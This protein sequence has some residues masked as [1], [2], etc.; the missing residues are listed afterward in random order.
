MV[1]CKSNDKCNHGHENK[2]GWWGVAKSLQSCKSN[3]KCNHDQTYFIIKDHIKF[4]SLQTVS[5]S[6]RFGQSHMTQVIVN[7]MFGHTRHDSMPLQQSHNS[8]RTHH[9]TD[10]CKD[11]SSYHADQTTTRNIRRHN[12]D[13]QPQ[14]FRRCTVSSDLLYQSWTH[15]CI[16]FEYAYYK[17]VCKPETHNLDKQMFVKCL[18]R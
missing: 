4:S 6:H 9:V 1:D 14:N 8:C 10:T 12:V 7:S 3:D 17:L 13:I 11:K 2:K 15:T 5:A 16:H 18:V